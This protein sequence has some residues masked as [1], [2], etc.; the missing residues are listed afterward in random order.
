MVKGGKRQ[1][2][3]MRNDGKWVRIYRLIGFSFIFLSESRD[4]PLSEHDNKHSLKDSISLFTH[5]SIKRNPAHY[6][7][8]RSISTLRAVDAPT[9]NRRFPRN[10]QQKSAEAALAQRGERFMW[11]GRHDSHPLEPLEVL[12]ATNHSTLYND[13]TTFNCIELH[14]NILLQT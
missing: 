7:M 5:V 6:E 1:F 10:H 2:S 13:L 4:F 12:A 9:S 3:P 8:F 11:F 14:L